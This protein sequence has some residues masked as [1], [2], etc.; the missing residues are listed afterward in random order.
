MKKKKIIITMPA[1]FIGGAERSL[2]GLLSEINY[3]MFNVDLFLYRHAGEFLPYIPN[4]VNI[5]REIKQYT[6]LERPIKD[7]CFEGNIIFGIARIFSKI[8][9]KFRCIIEK[10]SVST[11]KSMQYTSKYLL[12]LLPEIEGQYD[13]AINF[14]GIHDILINKISA[15]VKVGWMHT[16]YST[17]DPF[18]KMDELMWAK[19][20][21]IVNVSSECTNIFKSILPSLKQ[22]CLTIENILSPSFIKKQAEQDVSNEMPNEKEI[23]LCS[24]GRFSNAKNFDNA[25]IICKNLINLG[26]KLKWYIIGFGGEETIIRE[27]IRSYKMEEHFI[28]LGQKVN[29]Y[30]YLKACDIYIQ[31]SRYEGKAVTVREAQILCKPVVITNFQ[32]AKSQIK[33][34]FDGIIVPL[35]NEGCTKALYVIIKD[36]SIQKKLIENCMKSEFGNEGEVEKIYNLLENYNE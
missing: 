34:G 32:T 8:A 11:Y 17:L 28:I 24:I 3:E 18:L 23:K 30:P 15:K 1:L 27:N 9:L 36:T 26:L 25:V 12:P 4:K 7:L 29:P 10:K 16:D 22:K 6:T 2:I 13:L 14:L 19:L 31:P 35:D 5:L 33:D 21:Y 20:D